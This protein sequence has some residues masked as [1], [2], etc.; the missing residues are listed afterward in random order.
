MGEESLGVLET[1]SISAEQRDSYK[2][3][4]Q[5]FKHPFVRLTKDV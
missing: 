1:L 4:M 2:A 3:A 5:S